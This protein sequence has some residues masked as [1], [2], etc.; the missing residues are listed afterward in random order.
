MPTYEYACTSCGRR[1]D[2]MQSFS[3]APLEVCEVCGGKLKRVFHPVGIVLKG[4]GFYATDSRGEKKAASAPEK[5]AEKSGEK[6]GSDKAGDKS[7]AKSAGAPSSGTS[8]ETKS[9]AADPA[10]AKADKK[11]GKKDGAAAS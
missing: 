9:A 7:A 11:P 2:V 1:F 10:P 8:S 4:S 5:S 6:S 3:D